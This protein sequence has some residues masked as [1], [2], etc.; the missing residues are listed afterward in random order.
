MIPEQR[1][2]LKI[3]P[4]DNLVVALRDLSLGEA[5]EEPIDSTG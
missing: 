2:A 1:A 3:S 4:E 5:V